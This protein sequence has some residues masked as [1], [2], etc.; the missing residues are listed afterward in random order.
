MKVDN[1]LLLVIIAIS[2]AVNTGCKKEKP[3]QEQP[4]AA[5]QF[6][7]PSVANAGADQTITLR[8]ILL[9][10]MVMDLPILTII[11][12]VMHGQKFPD[13][14][15]SLLVMQILYKHK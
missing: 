12:P 2:L 9:L 4:G 14:L 3:P 10:L 15:H 5:F 13:H 7:R 1:L 6:N 8:Q 11:S